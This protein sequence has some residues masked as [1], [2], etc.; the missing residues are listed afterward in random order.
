[1]HVLLLY[2]DVCADIESPALDSVLGLR[3]SVQ[4]VPIT[5]SRTPSENGKFDAA[6]GKI[7]QNRQ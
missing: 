6:A 3:Q 1:M 2:D 5:L 4:Y 7:S